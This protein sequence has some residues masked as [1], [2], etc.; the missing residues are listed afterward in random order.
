MY[1]CV[2]VCICVCMYVRVNVFMFGNDYKCISHKYEQYGRVFK[3][4]NRNE[5]E[6]SYKTQYTTSVGKCLNEHVSIH[7]SIISA[8][9]YSQI[10]ALNYNADTFL[11]LALLRN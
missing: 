8:I 5:H 3:P 10:T 4:E 11:D 1:V 2:N 9:G 6:S 7:T